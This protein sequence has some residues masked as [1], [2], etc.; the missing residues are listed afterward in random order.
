MMGWFD[1]F[2][3]Y[4]SEQDKECAKSYV[5]IDMGYL[6]NSVINERIILAPHSL[7]VI[8]TFS[9]LNLT[10]ALLFIVEYKEPCSPSEEQ[11]YAIPFFSFP[12]S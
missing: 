12:H 2:K 10:H 6:E 1:W 4:I 5:L 11:P 3:S 7:R 8:I 9:F